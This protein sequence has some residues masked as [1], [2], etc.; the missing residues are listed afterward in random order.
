MNT[1]DFNHSWQ[2]TGRQPEDGALWSHDLRLQQQGRRLTGTLVHTLSRM[3][4]QTER[5]SREIRADL[6]LIGEPTAGGA[7]L[8]VT[9]RKTSK[10]LGRLRLSV[11]GTVL[12]AQSDDAALLDYTGKYELL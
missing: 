3:N 8:Y 1:N 11:Q 7:T 2:R 12:N 5:L 6:D 10:D 9:E 4:P